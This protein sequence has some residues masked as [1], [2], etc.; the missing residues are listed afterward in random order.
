MTDP[1]SVGMDPARVERARQ[2]LHEQV[3]SGRSPG[4]VAVVTR[5]GHPVLTEALGQRTPDGD[6]MQ[7]DSVWPVASVTKPLTATVVMSLVEDGEIG[8]VQRV[9]DYLPELPDGLAEGLLVH[10]LLT[11]TGGFETPLFNGRLRDRVRNHGADDAHFGRDP[12]VNGF[13]GC[14]ADLEVLAPPGTG[15]WY[16]S[17][18]YELLGEIVRRVTGQSVGDM[19]RDRVFAP[20]SL[21]DTA[22]VAHAAHRAR[23]VE[24]A[25]HLPFSEDGVEKIFGVTMEVALDSDSSGGGVTGTV[26]DI[27]RFGEMILGRG[28]LDGV[29]V[30]SPAAVRAMTT[31]QIPGVPD[32]TFGRPEASWGYGFSVLCEQR[33]PYF[34]GGLVPPGSVTHNGAGGIDHWIDFDHGISGALFEIT[35]ESSPM[36]EPISAV[37]H[38]FQDVITAAVIDE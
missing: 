28:E 34:G 13:L 20:L 21:H 37:G 3:D 38:R 8:L 31:N 30:L 29:R 17:L 5:H 36:F 23:Q 14:L 7:L 12:V 22:M 10:H 9:V 26:P 32:M 6:P 19:M 18:S 24:R 11:H 2:V 4:L 16:G 33:W 1:A 35:T 27:V 25:A 15:M